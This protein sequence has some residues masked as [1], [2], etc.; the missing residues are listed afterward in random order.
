MIIAAAFIG[1]LTAYYFGLRPGAFAAGAAFL[2][3]VA[4]LMMPGSALLFYGVV[5]VGVVGLL[6]AGPRYG[7]KGAR[8]DVFHVV[9]RASKVARGLWR[10][11]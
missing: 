6:F 7:R 3:F 9:G 8:T 11:L 5:S 2:L 4:A 10:K 1:L